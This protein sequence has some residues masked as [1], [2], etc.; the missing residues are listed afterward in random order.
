M[1]H[2]VVPFTLG[3]RAPVGLTQRDRSSR[4]RQF[5]RRESRHV[6]RA[7]DEGDNPVLWPRV[8]SQEG[9]RVQALLPHSKPG[10]VFAA[11]NG[12]SRKRLS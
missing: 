6:A 7:S 10:I 11:A 5:S 12:V 2:V 8:T 3:P 1:M 4:Q 9:L